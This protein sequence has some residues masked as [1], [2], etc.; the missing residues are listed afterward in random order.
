MNNPRWP[1]HAVMIVSKSKQSVET[2]SSPMT[3][4]RV[5]HLQVSSKLL[6]VGAWEDNATSRRIAV[7]DDCC[8]RTSQLVQRSLA[9]RRVRDAQVARGGS[10]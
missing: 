5:V 1:L 10:D 9:Q 2:Y 4:R 7:K 8:R 6:H 3:L